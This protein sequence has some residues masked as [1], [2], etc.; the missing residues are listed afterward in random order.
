MTLRAFAAERRHPS[1]IN[2]S[3]PRGAQ[4][5]TRRRPLLLSIG[6]TDKRADGRTLERYI[7]SAPRP[8]RA[9]S[10]RKSSTLVSI[11]AVHTWTVR[12]HGAVLI[13][14]S[15]VLSARA[16]SGLAPGVI[17]GRPHLFRDLPLPLRLLPRYQIILLD[18]RGT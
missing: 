17:D 3:C 16:G 5:Q 7:D 6:G 12:R 15:L 4:Q 1:S 11:A 18:D 10:E 9:V 2:I 8:M 14:V 13:S